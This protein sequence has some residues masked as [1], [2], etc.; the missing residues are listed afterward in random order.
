M[1][2]ILKNHY[3]Y[4]ISEEFNRA[5]KMVGYLGLIIQ[6]SVYY[7]PSELIDKDGNAAL[8]IK[9]L[10]NILKLRK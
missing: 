5:N 1:N 7:G 4:Q 8:R 10:G 2:F 3:I 6:P 9:G